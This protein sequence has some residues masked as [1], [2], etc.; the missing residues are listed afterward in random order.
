MIKINLTN[1]GAARTVILHVIETRFNEQ[2]VGRVARVHKK[3]F[4]EQKTVRTKTSTGD[5]MNGRRNVY[6]KKAHYFL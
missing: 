2:I 3:I 4:F 6:L 5:W 1:I